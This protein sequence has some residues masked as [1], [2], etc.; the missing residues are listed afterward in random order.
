MLQIKNI[1]KQY[2]TGDL[3]QQALDGV[4][5]TFRDNEFVAILGPSGSGKTT[6]LN[7]VGGLDRYDS[8]DLIINGVST[9]KYKD[10]DWDTYRNHSIGFVFQSYNLIS[11]Q[12]V[13]QNVELALTISGISKAERRKMAKEALERVGLGD[14]MHKKPNQMSGGQMQRVAIARALVNNPDILLADE[15][16]GALDTQTGIQVMELLKEVA[17]DRLVI[18]VTHN[19]EL[20]Q[21]YATRIINLR[22]GKIVDDSD[23]V[24]EKE[25]ILKEPDKRKRAS[26]SF[27][28]SL[29]LS[30]R[31]LLTKKRRTLTTA[32]AGSIGIIG[33]ALILS[34]SSGVNAY[35]QDVEE[36]TLSEYPLQITNSQLNLT[37]LMSSMSSAIDTGGSDAEITVTS[38]ISTLLSQ[39][40]SND[41][42]ALK[43]YLDSDE[44]DLS[45]YAAAIE[46]LY[47][48][49]PEI[50]L[51]E[52]EDIRRVNPDNTLVS[53]DSS[54]FFS[55]L[56][57]LSGSV[58]SS[59]YALPE[60]ETLYVDQYEVLA[61]HWPE[62]EHECILVLSSD[63]AI[64]DYMLYMLG[65]RDYSE[66]ETMLRQYFNGEE[67][68]EIEN[69]GSYS[70]EDVLGITFK[71]V[72]SADY[73]V[74]DS[75]YNVWV[76]KTDNTD[77]LA[78]LVENGEDLRIVG[79]VK[80]S[81]DAIASSL[82]SGIYYPQSLIYHMAEL[83]EESDA[84]QAQLAHPDVNIFTGE[85]FGE[86]SD[87]F[88]LQSVISVNED[89]LSDLFDADAFTDTDLLMDSDALSA[90]FDMDSFS[91]D[92]DTS[93][94]DF[95]MDSM[96]LDVSS[97]DFD[98]DLDSMDLSDFDLDMNIELDSGSMDLSE[99]LDLGSIDLSSVDMDSIEIDLSGLDM[100]EILEGI[101]FDISADSV[102]ALTTSLLEGYEAYLVDHPGAS[103]TDLVNDF[104]AYLESDEASAILTDFLNNQL[105]NYEISVPTDG[106][107]D[108]LE[109]LQDEN[110]GNSGGNTIAD[111][112]TI[113]DA[114]V[115]YI[116]ENAE[117]TVTLNEADFTELIDELA[118]GY[119]TYAETNSLTTAD[120]ITASFT[121]YLASDEAAQILSDG[122][123]DMIDTLGI[124]EQ[125][126]AVIEAYMQTALASVM[127]SYTDV[128]AAA[129]ETQ[130]SAA[131]GEMMTELSDDIQKQLTA[132]MSSVMEQMMGQIMTQISEEIST[133]ISSQMSSVMASMTDEI[134]EQV[135]G[136]I[137]ESMEI[138]M[139]D[140]LTE[141][142]S[143]LL[144]NLA[145]SLSI[146]A[147]S[148]SEALGFNMDSDALLELL[149][150]MSSSTSTDYATNLSALG[151]VDFDTPGE[152][153]IYPRD[154][155]SKDEIVAVLDAYNEQ[156]E[157]AGK[158]EKVISYTDLVGT[159][160]SSVTTII[161]IISYVLIAFV[162]ISLV[163]S[164]IMISI[165][166]Q[167]SVLERTRE[168]G[169]LRAIG[170]S[171]RNISQVFNAETFII[172][173]SSGLIGVIVS[174]L[175]T[176]PMNMIIHSIAGTDTVNAILTWN[177]ALILVIVSIVITVLSGL[178]PALSAAKK[179]PVIALRT[180]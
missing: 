129:I 15:P 142:M 140:L 41:L 68:T 128:L 85:A 59:F 47:N 111:T 98:I 38:V 156:M 118:S 154:F 110:S 54:S 139:T 20:A 21:E 167:I 4:S 89:A 29:G 108:L 91:L 160:M 149:T 116:T 93:S 77:Y 147:E 131:M 10:R 126:T 1:Y 25:A 102:N 137:S 173:I 127:T 148:L 37:S 65:L 31:N 55:S 99:Y 104:S 46:Y 177:N 133:Q 70:Y 130:L 90:A 18:M 67:V 72:C 172:G 123:M 23:P 95:D 64:S 73:Y 176:I 34:L 132:Q 57:S 62:N 3:V 39:M 45:E 179:D 14:Q 165:I 22:D 157:A 81:E 74:Y 162:A 159:M 153:D 158:P 143:A 28:T 150:S 122:L 8:G 66:L 141:S 52:E 152:I 163:V 2:R 43:A 92:M 35:I 166:T 88:D 24:T 40:D 69:M 42:T 138:M 61:G 83:A 71:V 76:D 174:E 171:R 19:P 101:T 96:E 178:A 32:V 169:I 120:S 94:L 114:I 87:E 33:I 75:E 146:D 84:V 168:I 49:E 60:S 80:P 16:T 13:L 119:S 51:Q 103:Y 145:G 100:S 112:E 151:Y 109:S 113:V 12:S 155:A 136:R 82:T 115:E 117:V 106:L 180:E 144:E 58:T 30:F 6:L 9:K 121:D 5:L 164:C 17:E 27:R 48:L 44:A 135:S 78:G 63:G 79:V 161:N 105:A 124:Q 56:M 86:D 50:Y 7:I 175:L 36:D 170:A 26:M 107:V 11:H 134:M 53:S 125:V 97:M